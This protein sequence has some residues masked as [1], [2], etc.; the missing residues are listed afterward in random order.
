[1]ILGT[2][3]EAVEFT[4]T[5]LELVVDPD[6]ELPGADVVWELEL[7]ELALRD[8]DD[9]FEDEELRSIDPVDGRDE[10]V[11]DFSSVL[12]AVLELLDAGRKVSKQIPSKSKHI[13]VYIVPTY[14]VDIFELHCRKEEQR[15]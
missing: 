7:L 8:T 11:E 14:L 5:D 13:Y 9:P 10:E 2:G 15:Q 3:I 12:D 4:L 6:D 1:V